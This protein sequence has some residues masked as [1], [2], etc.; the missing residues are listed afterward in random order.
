MRSTCRGSNGS[1]GERRPL[2]S[3]SE[4][5]YACTANVQVGGS[6]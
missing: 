2:A 5:S 3:I 4:E 6:G 1:E